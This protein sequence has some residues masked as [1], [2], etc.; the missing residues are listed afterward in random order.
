[1]IGAKF[2]V[3]P[4]EVCVEVPVAALLLP[5]NSPHLL[6]TIPDHGITILRTVVGVAANHF[7]GPY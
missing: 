2:A 5:G 3:V 7:R 1:M 4:A 6:D